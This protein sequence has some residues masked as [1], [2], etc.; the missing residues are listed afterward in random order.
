ME[1]LPSITAA[2]LADRL[3]GFLRGDGSRIVRTVAPLDEAGPDTLSWLGSPDY[4]PKLAAS[5]A[6]VVLIPADCEVPPKRTTIRVSDPDLALCEALRCLA[7]PTE[8]V[9]AGINPAAR[10][11]EDAIVDGACLGPHVY[12]GP[13]AAVGPG[14]QLHPGVYIGADSRIG[15]DCVLWPNVV[16]REYTTLG[17]RVIVHPNATIGADGFGYHM[18]GGK[19]IKIPQ[20]GRVV[21]ED[22]V[23]IGAGT[24]VDRARSGITRIGR[25]TKI[26]N[27]VQIAHNV[28]IDEDC[29]VVGQCGISGS[30]TLGKNVVLS[31]QVGVVDHLRIGNQVMVAAQSGV[32]GDIPDGKVY[33]GTPAVENNDYGRQAVAVRRLPKMIVQLRALTKRVEQLESAAN[34]T[35]RS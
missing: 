16:V 33:R 30:V 12:V 23:E 5:K 2:D 18:R 32:F 4:L 22:D 29:I 14:T 28:T 26:D 25:G 10:V 19:H 24:C 1:E 7:P 27:L 31:G 35:T 15:H 34:D 8:P 3:G 20:I 13:R 11:A 17:E 6:G 9:P 21:I